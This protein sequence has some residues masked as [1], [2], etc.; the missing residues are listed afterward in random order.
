LSL[1]VFDHVAIGTRALPDGWD[2][3]GGLLGG[4]WVYGG[5]S[6]GFWWG[7]LQ[8]RSGPK[9]ELLT[10]SGGPDSAF[11]ERFLVG[12]GAGPHHFNFIV[13][14]IHATLTRIRAV[15]IEPVQ[16][17]LASPTWKEAFLHP[18]NAYGIVVQVAQPSGATPTLPAPAELPA[19]GLPS[20]FTLVEHTV[21]DIHGAVRLFADAL[22]G[23]VVRRHETAQAS[24]AELTWVNGARL[25]LV[26]PGPPASDG[27]PRSG[28]G[29]I[30]AEEGLRCVRFT[31]DAAQ[32]TA[33]DRSR[34]ADLARRLGV[35]L[36]LGD[37]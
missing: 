18:K 28:A 25:R 29:A 17:S 4:S 20:D 23:E 10:P 3:F 12:R 37:D 14:D 24:V 16:V 6:P 9:I 26:Q 7:Q 31:R 27:T 21:S 15:G 8:F 13:P 5:D 34:A 2:L 32:F 36:Q 19:A 1:P 35:P 30:R 11:L 22:E 33:A